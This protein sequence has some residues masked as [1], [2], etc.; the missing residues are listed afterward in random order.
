MAKGSDVANWAY[1]AGFNTTDLLVTA[2]AVAYG[3]SSWNES[4]KN[5]IGAGHYGLWQISALHFDPKKVKW[6]HGLINATLA[7]KVYDKQGWKAWTVYSTGGYKLYIEKAKTA[8]AEFKSRFPTIGIGI[9]VNE[10]TGGVSDA[11]GGVV[12]DVLAPVKEFADKLGFFFDPNNWKRLGFMLGG[13][14][15][16]TVAL[17]VIMKN[18]GAG[19]A[20]TTAVKKV[21]KVA[22]KAKVKK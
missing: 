11:V 20:V 8:A 19:A 3:E 6:D 9:E 18:T 7:K 10:F 13:A 21:G 5:N 1:Q 14:A 2:L 15:M 12:D 17:I 16:M 22:A 4:A